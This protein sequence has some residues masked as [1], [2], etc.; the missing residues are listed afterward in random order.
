MA[1]VTHSLVKALRSVPAFAAL[2]DGTLLKIVGASSN[3]FWA[4]GSEVF[5]KGSPS[6]ALYI[7]LTGEVQVFDT[8]DGAEVDVAR[9]E[10]GES[11]GELSLMLQA[12]HSKTARAAEDSELMVIPRD[13]FTEVLASS[14]ELDA[15]FRRRLEERRPLR[16]DR[17]S[18]G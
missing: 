3:L 2:D 9:I 14:P 16:G 5:E 7:V 6:E 11:F 10:P 18:A 12:K 17:A 13:S 15:V 8:V 4:A 1:R